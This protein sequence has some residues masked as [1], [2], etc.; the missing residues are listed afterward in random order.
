ME[1]NKKIADLI[2]EALKTE[3]M[4]T[5]E[6]ELKID[7]CEQLIRN[8]LNTNLKKKG[9]VSETG[10]FKQRYKVYHL[11]IDKI[12]DN[13]ENLED[14]KKLKKLMEDRMGFTSAPDDNEIKF[15]EYLKKKLESKEVID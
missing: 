6:L 4:T 15:V 8:V 2:I 5:L 14:L 1:N 9:I 10:K 7:K 13:K 3:D 12:V 11:N